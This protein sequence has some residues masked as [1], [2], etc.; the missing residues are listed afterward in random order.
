MDNVLNV[1]NIP[2]GTVGMNLENFRGQI[3]DSIF[4]LTVFTFWSV[5]LESSLSPSLN[6]RLKKEKLF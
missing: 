2:L 1:V 4:F 6:V 3:R 5:T